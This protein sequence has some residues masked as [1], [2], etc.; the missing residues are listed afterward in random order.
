[1]VGGHQHSVDTWSAPLYRRRSQIPALAGMGM[2][3]AAGEITG[4]L[5][6]WGFPNTKQAL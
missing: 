4:A 6:A 5:S 2:G 1:M 3:G